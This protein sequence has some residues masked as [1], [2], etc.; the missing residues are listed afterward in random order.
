MKKQKKPPVR[1]LPLQRLSSKPV[2]LTK[3]STPF[4]RGNKNNLPI[5]CYIV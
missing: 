4:W 2:I 5:L 3:T 1:F